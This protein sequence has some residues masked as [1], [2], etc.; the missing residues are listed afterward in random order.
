MSRSSVIDE[1]ALARHNARRLGFSAGVAAALV[2]LLAASVLRLA[3]GVIS[4][5]EIV[6]DGFL[7]LLPGELF[8]AIL[9]ALQRSAKPLMYLGVGI[10]TLVVGGLL[11][12]WY[13]ASPGWRQAARIVV[14]VWLVFGLGVY[15]L[16]GAGPFGSHLQ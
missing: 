15:T 9:D 7:L 11:G 10:A 1:A 16:G 8:S 5:P 14:V 12:R 6:A 2:M 13:A 3:S 4:L